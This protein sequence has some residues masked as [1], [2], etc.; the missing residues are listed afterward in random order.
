VIS[1]GQKPRKNADKGHVVLRAENLV[2][3]SPT[4]TAP[5]LSVG[6][7]VSDLAAFLAP[8]APDQ[9]NTVQRIRHWTREG[10]LR[11]IESSA[12]AGPGNHRLYSNA[13]VYSAAFLHVYTVAGLPISHSRFL[14]TI[15]P[16]VDAAAAQWL[17]DQKKA[18]K[19]FAEQKKKGKPAGFA[20]LSRLVIGMNAAGEIRTVRTHSTSRGVH[21]H[22]KLESLRDEAM[23]LEFDLA[24]IFAEVDRGR[25]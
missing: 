7:T 6:W 18:E 2:S 5:A 17:A 1:V 25:S 13:A 9:P 10:I 14:K 15:M 20:M 16:E 8:I 3:G 4:F 22:E 11:P 24:R 23:V 12:H 21:F 19:W